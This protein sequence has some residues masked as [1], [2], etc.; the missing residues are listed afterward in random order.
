M[1]ILALES[2]I[3]HKKPDEDQNEQQTLRGMRLSEDIRWNAKRELAIMFLHAATALYGT[4]PCTFAASYFA[5]NASSQ[6]EKR[7]ALDLGTL[8]DYGPGSRNRG[9]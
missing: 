8:S 1:F 4:Q 9:D 5:F 7:Y 3:G 6:P 2:I